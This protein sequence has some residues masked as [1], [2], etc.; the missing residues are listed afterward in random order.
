MSARVSHWKAEAALV[1]VSFIW[2]ST[3]IL[4]KEALNDIS[5]L[6]F[7]SIRFTVATAGLWFLYRGKHLPGVTRRQEW[8]AGFAVGGCLFS[9]YV[10]QTIGLK[11]T[12][13][14]KAGFLTGMYIVLVPVLM[15]AVHRTVPHAKETIGF[16]VSTFGL[17]LLTLPAEGF[18]I[19][20]GDLIVAGCALP[21]AM[22][23]LVLGHFAP[24]VGFASVGFHQIAAGAL[25]GWGVCWWL[26]PIH[27]KWSPPVLMAL[28]VT[29]ILATAVAFALQSW[30]QQYTTP[31]RAALIFTMEPVFA[32]LTS[33]I[34]AGEILSP[35]AT[36]GALLI[37][38]GIVAVEWRR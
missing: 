29:S 20:R 18:A 25:L 4:V 15:A 14:S 37:L 8:L 34:V 7:L 17:V 23:I 19:A 28:A 1:F 36:M 26:E 11:F 30:A 31:T 35:R 32:W 6:L 5:A 10:F 33:F 3:F 21:Y 22:H 12:S 27:V 24:R 13:A 16:A 2:G 38:A 9:G